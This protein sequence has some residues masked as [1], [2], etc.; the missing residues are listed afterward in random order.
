MNFAE[1]INNDGNMNGLAYAKSLGVIELPDYACELS[2][3]RVKMLVNL[4]ANN[5]VDGIYDIFK[6]DLLPRLL[7]DETI[8]DEW[9]EDI[10]AC[11]DF[12]FNVYDEMMFN[13]HVG[14]AHVKEFRRLLENRCDKLISLEDFENINQMLDE[15]EDPDETEILKCIQFARI[16]ALNA[17]RETDKE[18]ALKKLEEESNFE[19]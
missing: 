10:I 14:P 5:E 2:A 18:E 4:I 12:G 17:K 1:Y 15:V 11:L 6:D 19:E 16:Q 7:T 9:V 8:D 3:S 13:V